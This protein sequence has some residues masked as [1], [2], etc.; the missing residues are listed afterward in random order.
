[1]SI[2]RLAAID[3]WRRR[4]MPVVMVVAVATATSL[5]IALPLMQAAAAEEGLRSAL[6]SLGRGANLEIVHM[7]RLHPIEREQCRRVVRRHVIGAREQ[8]AARGLTAGRS[9]RSEQVQSR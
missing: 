8:V 9:I 5:A 1:M 7:L 2:F 6:Q 4:A 3:L